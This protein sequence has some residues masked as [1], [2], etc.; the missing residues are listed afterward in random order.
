VCSQ[1]LGFFCAACPAGGPPEE[2]PRGQQSSQL[3]S[4]IVAQAN[5]YNITVLW[6]TEAAKSS[7]AQL[8]CLGCAASSAPYAGGAA[9]C[10][11][12][13]TAGHHAPR[14]LSLLSQQACA[15][16]GGACPAW[17]HR[18][19][20]LANKHTQPPGSYSCM[21]QVG[22]P[23]L[24]SVCRYSCLYIQHTVHPLPATLKP[25]Q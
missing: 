7:G 16:A 20:S 21:Q 2:G 24:I 18:A 10:S 1:H 11:A 22:P 23:K 5:M 3:A 19:A 8:Q 17:R 4:N 12:C 25:G 15:A 13:P 6:P 9:A 14:M